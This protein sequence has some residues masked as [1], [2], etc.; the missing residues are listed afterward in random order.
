MMYEDDVPFVPDKPSPFLGPPDRY[1]L[2]IPHLYRKSEF[3]PGLP[4]FSPK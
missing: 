1:D 2:S 4:R 3:C